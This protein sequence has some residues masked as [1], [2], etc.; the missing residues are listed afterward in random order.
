MRPAT[1]TATATVTAT[2]TAQQEQE[3]KQE[4]EGKKNKNEA[5]RTQR[6]KVDDL[7]EQSHALLAL[8]ALLGADK[9]RVQDHVDQVGEASSLQEAPLPLLLG[10][11]LQLL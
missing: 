7:E 4:S 2:A 10:Q 9:V 5:P 11:L 8:A 3:Q 1:A 6:E